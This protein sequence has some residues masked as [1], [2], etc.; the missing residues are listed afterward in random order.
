MS[1]FESSAMCPIS[2][3]ETCTTKV[4][5]QG[6]RQL[7]PFGLNGEGGLSRVACVV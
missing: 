2:N 5:A 7:F 6:G 1:S 4:D 3:F